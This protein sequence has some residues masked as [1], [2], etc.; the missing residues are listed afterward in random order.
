MTLSKGESQL[1]LELIFPGDGK[2]KKSHTLSW[3]YL[4]NCIPISEKAQGRPSKPGL[5]SLPGTWYP[6]L[7]GLFFN[8]SQSSLKT[9]FKRSVSN[10]LQ[11]LMIC[12]PGA[13]KGRAQ[14]SS[15]QRKASLPAPLPCGVPARLRSKSKTALFHLFVQL[16]IPVEFTVPSYTHLSLCSF[17]YNHSHL[18]VTQKCFPQGCWSGGLFS[19]S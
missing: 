16:Y 19:S 12:S 7:L 5:K 3:F 13:S 4:R 18:I 11:H 14:Q 8:T 1:R 10:S 17:T 2:R 6:S 9:I 15:Y